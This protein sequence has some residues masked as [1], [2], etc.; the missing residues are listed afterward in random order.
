VEK[1]TEPEYP[2]AVEAEGERLVVVRESPFNAETPADALAVG[3]TRP[4]FVRSHFDVPPIDPRTHRLRVGGAVARPLELSLAELR[5]TAWHETVVTLECAGNGR[6]HMA[7]LP[8]GEP[9]LDGAVGTARWGGVPLRLVLERAMLSPAAVEILAIGADRGTPNGD[10]AP[11]DMQFAR[12]LP[13][14]RALDED[15][16]LAVEM[17]G[18]PLPLH[19][20]A[21]LRLIVPR[22]FGVASVKWLERLEALTQPYDGWFQ[23]ARYVYSYTD[24]RPTE[25]VREL[26]CKSMIVSPGDG[27][28]LDRGRTEI[29]GWAWSGSAEVASV[30]LSVDSSDNWLAATL[31]PPLSRNAWR[32]FRGWWDAQTPGRHTLRARA[33][34]AAGNHQ[35]DWPRNNRFGY[36]NNAIRPVIVDV[37]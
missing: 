17:N 11:R 9:W 27:A 18:A 36:G 28:Q 19:H 37:R 35:P 32:G 2:R 13:L 15:T 22:W 31:D 23:E 8:P 33:T 14:A 3:V 7:P 10:G 6:T 34:D 26:R 30:E 29:R 12:S 20:G 21:P 1:P 25:P 4:H 5:A 16:L 24:D